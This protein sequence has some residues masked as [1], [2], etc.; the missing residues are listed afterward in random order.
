MV[1]K[2]VTCYIPERL[3]HLSESDY[4]KISEARN[5]LLEFIAREIDQS[6]GILEY[7]IRYSVDKKNG[8]CEIT[9]T[10]VCFEGAARLIQ[11]KCIRL[12]ENRVDDAL[13]FSELLMR[14]ALYDPERSLD[15]TIYDGAELH[16]YLEIYALNKCRVERINYDLEF[17]TG[18][19]HERN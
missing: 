7:K 3:S 9:H 19:K 4:K 6:N 16:E 13:R 8:G 14:C 10:H 1:K 5:Y 17:E 11:E 12:V 15:L 18:I 2:L